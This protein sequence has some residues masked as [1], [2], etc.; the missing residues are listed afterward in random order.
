M[1]AARRS[2]WGWSMWPCPRTWP[3]WSSSIA[4]A[5]SAAT[6]S[7]RRR[8]MPRSIWCCRCLR[9]IRRNDPVV[10][11]DHCRLSCPCGVLGARL[12]RVERRLVDEALFDAP[13]E[14]ILGLYDLERDAA[15]FGAGQPDMLGQILANDG[16][17]RVGGTDQ[18][19]GQPDVTGHDYSPN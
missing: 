4:S 6:R 16:A 1:A 13:D 18:A 19:T 14:R 9:A 17:F 8:W 2:R 12:M 3:L 5:I 11:P 10:A 7:A 15:G